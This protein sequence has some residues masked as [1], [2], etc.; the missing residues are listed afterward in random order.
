MAALLCV[1]AVIQSAIAETVPRPR[2]R[3]T[4]QAGCIRTMRDEPAGS[5]R[6]VLLRW[7]Q[8][9]LKPATKT[10]GPHG[11]FIY[12]KGLKYLIADSAF[13]RMQVDA[14]GACRLDGDEHHLGLALR[15]AERLR[16]CPFFRGISEVPFQGRQDRF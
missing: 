6:R 14:H 7:V 11:V 10:L 5:R 9:A 15:N 16:R 2:T 1:I 8:F 4:P 13:K 12:R 3:S